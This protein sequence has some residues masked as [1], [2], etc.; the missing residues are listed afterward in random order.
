M[1]S[2]QPDHETTSEGTS[3]EAGAE[4]NS[5][6]KARLVGFVGV[7]VLLAVAAF[8]LPITEW[9]TSLVGWIGDNRGI[10]WLV[11]ILAY[12]LATVLLL[13]GSIL[14]LSAGFL[15]GLPL[16]FALVSAGSVIGACCSFLLG[17]YFARDWVAEKI[18]GNAKF[19]ALDNAVRDKGFVIVLLTRLSPV[20][21]FN[22][23]NYAMGITGVKFGSYALGSW[24]GMMP[25]TVLYVYLGSAAQ[26][27]SEVF[28]G[29]AASGNNWLL[30]VGLAATLILTIVITRF[31]T[32]ALNSE[33]EANS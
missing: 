10:S 5:S 3:I 16:G 29:E 21:P 11:F 7:L 30:Y 26:N 32:Q 22:L 23:L 25:G 27:L 18:D 6:N 15:F 17:R 9:L 14:T 12:I 2:S 33:L 19:S 28:S 20:F 13:P 4:S 24:I 31:A 8:T 1:T